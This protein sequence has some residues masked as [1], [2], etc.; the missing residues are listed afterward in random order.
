[1]GEQLAEAVG[2]A[3]GEQ[4]LVGV[5]DEAAGPGQPL[6][7]GDPELEDAARVGVAGRRRRA[8]TSRQARRQP[9]ACRGSIHGEPRSRLIRSGAAGRAAAAAGPWPGSAA[10]G[11][12]RAG[13]LPSGE[14]A[15][16]E[17]L[18][19][20]LLG[21]RTSHPEV[22]GERA[23][24]GQ[25]VA[26]RERAGDD[27]VA[28]LGRELYAEGLAAGRGRAGREGVLVAMSVLSKWSRIG[29]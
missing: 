20:G 4:H 10:G 15:L 5:D 13:T 11:H 8:E 2:R 12:E 9:A 17:Q 25:P 3:R 7:D 26:G 23:G 6:G 14:P 21:D 29:P 1:M 19:V 22:G 27:Q 16:G 18:V 28:D 24:A